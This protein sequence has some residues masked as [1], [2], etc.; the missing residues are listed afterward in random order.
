MAEPV[1]GISAK[2]ENNLGFDSIESQGAS[3]GIR[4]SCGA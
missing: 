1:F 2:V 4:T 3:F